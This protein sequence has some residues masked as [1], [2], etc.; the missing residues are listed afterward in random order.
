MVYLSP[1]RPGGGILIVCDADQIYLE[2]G[3]WNFHMMNS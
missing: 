3:M 2:G 1:T